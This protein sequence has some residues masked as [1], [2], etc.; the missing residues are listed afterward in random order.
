MKVTIGP[1]LRYY[2]NSRLT[3]NDGASVLGDDV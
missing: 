1:G 3:C 2:P